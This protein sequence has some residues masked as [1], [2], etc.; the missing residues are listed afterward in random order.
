[1]S[2]RHGSATR[3]DSAANDPINAQQVEPDRD[4]DDVHDRIDRPDL[5]K[6]D[7]LNRRAMHFG[8]SLGDGH[9][10]RLRA[11]LLRFGQT[12]GCVDQRRDVAQMPMSVLLGMLDLNVSGAK[13]AAHDGRCLERDA[14]ESQRFDPRLNGFRI[15]SGIDQRRQRHVPS[16]PGRAIQI[17][18]SHSASFEQSQVCLR[19]SPQSGRT[20]GRRSRNLEFALVSRR[21]FSA[22]SASLRCPENSEC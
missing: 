18:N 15:H 16:N 14:L 10:D 12:V 8:L 20:I 7:F 4:A 9:E 2:D 21:R 6:V 19:E 1:M 22:L 13:A 11:E 3:R 5:V 17:S